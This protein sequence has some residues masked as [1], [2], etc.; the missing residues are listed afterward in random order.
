LWPLWPC[1]AHR[2]RLALWYQLCLADRVS[3]PCR[4]GPDD[5]VCHAHPWPLF[6]EP[7]FSTVLIA[8]PCQYPPIDIDQIKTMRMRGGIVA[9]LTCAQ[10]GAYVR[11]GSKADI[12]TALA[13]VP[14]TPK[15][16][17]CAVGE[18]RF[19]LGHKRTLRCVSR[20]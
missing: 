6:F 4:A 14:F 9:T 20:C 16:R 3:Q 17:P 19:A 11:F 7:I 5:R 18:P 2:A 12:C 15:S 13:H 8:E 1:L 10:K